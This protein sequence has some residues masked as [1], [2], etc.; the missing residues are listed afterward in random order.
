ML[1]VLLLDCLRMS[2]PAKPDIDT[3]A[4]QIVTVADHLAANPA[5]GPV[6]LAVADNGSLL[7]EWTSGGRPTSVGPTWTVPGLDSN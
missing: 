4:D 2:T 1:L 3:T 7:A 6:R 5:D